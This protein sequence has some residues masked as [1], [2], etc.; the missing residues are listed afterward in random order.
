[1]KTHTNKSFLDYLTL[2]SANQYLRED[3]Q[4]TTRKFNR[5][6]KWGLDRIAAAIAILI[7]SPILLTVAILIFIRMGSPIVFTQQR[8]GKNGNIFTFYKFRTMNNRRDSNGNLLPDLER[9]STLGKFLRQ[10]S[11]DELP[12]LWNVLKGDKSFVGPRPL[13][14]E[15]IERYSPEQFRRHDVLPGITGW[16]QVNGRNSISWSEKFKLD[17]W[18]VNNWT[19]GLDLKILFLTLWKVI[20]KD[21]INKS[22]REIMEIFMG[23]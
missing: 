22:D 11:L 7:F 14:V 13:L 16:A 2:A 3:H 1:M 10:T 19:L 4:A 18:Y 21:G 8:P 17:A 9:I 5:L 20:K 12:Q 15:Y 6:I 23:D